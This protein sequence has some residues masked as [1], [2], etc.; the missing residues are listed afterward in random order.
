MV[1]AESKAALTALSQLAPRFNAATDALM[2]EL[3]EIEA[4][5]EKLK[6]GLPCELTTEP[7]YVRG[8]EEEEDES[9]EMVTYRYASRVAYERLT[10]GWGLTVKDYRGRRNANGGYGDW[11]LIF[12]TPLLN[13]AREMRIAAAPLVPALLDLLVETTAQSLHLLTTVADTSTREKF[14][15]LLTEEETAK[16]LDERRKDAAMVKRP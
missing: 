1:L 9:G 14:P 3:R 6:I 16:L 15:D 5:L 11:T 2:S 12:T 7:I 8:D 10:A 13:S 4:T